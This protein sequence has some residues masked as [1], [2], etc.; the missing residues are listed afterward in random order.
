MKS[1]TAAVTLP[2]A[3]FRAFVAVIL[4]LGMMIPT[5]LTANRAYAD[6]TS[7]TYSHGDLSISSDAATDNVIELEVGKTATTP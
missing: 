6:Q 7:T 4:A 5:S 2:S 1:N 3:A